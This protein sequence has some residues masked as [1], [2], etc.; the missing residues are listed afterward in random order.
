[1]RPRHLRHL[2]AWSCL[3]MALACR[4]SLTTSPGANNLDDAGPSNRRGASSCGL[5]GAAFCDNFDQGPTANP[6]RE[7]DLDPAQWSAGRLSPQE[8]SG[9]GKVNPAPPAQIP[10]CRASLNKSTVYPDEDTLICDPTQTLSPQL[11]TAVAMQNYGLNSYRIRQPFDFAGRTGKIVFDVDAV[12]MSGLAAWVSVEVTEDPI[13]SPSFLEF[14]RGPVPRNGIEIQFNNDAC[15][16]TQQGRSISVGRVDAYRDYTLTP[17]THVYPADWTLP[18][19]VATHQGELNHFE[20]RISQTQF[21][22]LGSDASL[23][24]G[25]TFANFHTIASGT[26][27]LAFTRGYVHITARNHATEKYGFGPNWVYHWD[28]VAFDGPVISNWREYEVPDSLTPSSLPSGLNINTGYII[29]ESNGMFTCCPNQRVSSLA[30][31]GVDLTGAVRAQLAFSSFYLVCCGAPD[32][33]TTLDLKYRF[34][35]GPW[36][37]RFV[38]PAEA[39]ALRRPYSIGDLSQMI[40]VP[41]G[42]LIPGTN[43]LE[44]LTVNQP[45]SYPTVLA[46]IDL[47]IQTN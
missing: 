29:T 14:E 44:F 36:R 5:D 45:Q 40:D 30:L 34:N 27:D 33:L 22:I 37:D 16:R 32:D 35:G 21:E 25:K 41:L 26:F 3:T 12:M 7:G 46:N 1:M 39:L 19:C 13:P 11:L 47:I 38:T 20:I 42:D 18:D 9:P 10:P 43:T 17:V 28:N 4:A 24:G 2:L 23:D 15:D 8:I 31:P 6:G